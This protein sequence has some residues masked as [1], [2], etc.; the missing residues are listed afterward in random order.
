MKIY[1]TN[2]YPE[3]FDYK[4]YGIINSINNLL[5]IYDCLAIFSF[6]GL[7]QVMINMLFTH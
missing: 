2:Y 6:E 4:N 7:A 3:N 5:L 1:C